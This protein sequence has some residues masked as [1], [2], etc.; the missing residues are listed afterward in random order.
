[1]QKGYWFVG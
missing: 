1:L